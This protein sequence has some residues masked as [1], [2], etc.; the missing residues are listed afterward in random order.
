MRDLRNK[1]RDWGTPDWRDADAYPSRLSHEQWRWE[2]YRRRADYRKEWSAARPKAGYLKHLRWA[3]GHVLIDPRLPA[4]QL[5]EFDLLWVPRP[6]PRVRVA[7]EF[8]G[9]APIAPQIRAAERLLRGLQRKASA[10]GLSVRASRKPNAQAN[11]LWARYLRVLDA[12]EAGATFREIGQ[13]IHDAGDFD[14]Q[15]LAKQDHNRAR[16]LQEVFPRQ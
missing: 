13:A 1:L 7:F 15:A 6:R 11:N 8:D 3:N 9:L 5:D 2:F 12:R 10:V 4:S 14:D 16:S